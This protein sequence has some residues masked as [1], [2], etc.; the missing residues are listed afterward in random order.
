ME[1]KVQITDMGLF[2]EMTQAFGEMCQDKRI[3]EEVR[4]EYVAKVEDIIDRNS[5]EEP[6]DA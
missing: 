3:P 6:V 2:K 5:T 4:K 1:L